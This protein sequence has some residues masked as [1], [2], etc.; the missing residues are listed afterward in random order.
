MDKADA[1]LSDE[2]IEVLRQYYYMKI[3]L[4]LENFM[5]GEMKVLSYIHYTAGG[6]EIATGDIVS[7]LDM[8]GGRVAGI[9]RSLEKKGFISR[10]TDEND[11]RR[12]MVSPTPAGSDYVEN[13][14]E[15]LRSRLSAIINAMGSESAENFIR[16]MEE[17]VNACRKADFP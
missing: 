11:R 8:T 16:S 6:G 14:R 9:L 5:Q 2:L 12:I 1:G 3:P 7:A 10:R 17:F 13:G 4:G 15:L